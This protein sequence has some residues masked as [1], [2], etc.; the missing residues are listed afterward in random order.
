VTEQGALTL[1]QAAVAL[2]RCDRAEGKILLASTPH[3]C[4][5]MLEAKFYLDA[6]ISS[7]T[8]TTHTQEGGGTASVSPHAALVV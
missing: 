8:D 2:A 1:E 3:E 4:A 7:H 5:L 6:K